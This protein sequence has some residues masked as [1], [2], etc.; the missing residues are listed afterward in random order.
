MTLAVINFSL[1]QKT[2]VYEAPPTEF[3]IRLREFDHA[4]N[5]LGC[6]Q[7][8]ITRAA[9]SEKEARNKAYIAFDRCTILS[10]LAKES[11]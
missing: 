8:V 2:K 5:R 3:E 1:T 6:V 9:S 7:R 10:C 4:N 11:R